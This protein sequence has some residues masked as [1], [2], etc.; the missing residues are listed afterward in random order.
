[1]AD[2]RAGL[3]TEMADL[4]ADLRT[5]MAAGHEDLRR[6]MQQGFD[7]IWQAMTDLGSSL[8]REIADARVETFRW[9]FVFW[10]GQVAVLIGVLAFML[11]GIAPR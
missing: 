10:I 1:M 5:E 4:R 11:R 7:R 3:R 8:R 9:S 6:E 2:L